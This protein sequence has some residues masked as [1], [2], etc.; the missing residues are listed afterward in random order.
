MHIILITGGVGFIVSNFIPY[1]IENNPNY[2]IINLDSLTYA[3]DLINVSEVENHPRY[4]F[5]R[6]F[7]ENHVTIGF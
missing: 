2:H 5:G 3:G 6:K 4:T 7:Y 1:F